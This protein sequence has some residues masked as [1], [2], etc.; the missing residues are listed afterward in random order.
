MTCRPEYNGIDLRPSEPYRVKAKEMKMSF[1][2]LASMSALAIMIATPAPAQAPHSAA[3]AKTIPRTPDGHPDFQG[4]WTNATITPMERPA[5]FAGKPTITPA[6][7]K[8]H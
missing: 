2:F 7:A 4:V 6:E 5:A 1:R 3:K 8:E